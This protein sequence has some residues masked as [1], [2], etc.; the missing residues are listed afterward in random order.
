MK[1]CLGSLKFSLRDEKV[2]KRRPFRQKKLL[3]A[4]L[5]VKLKV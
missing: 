2:L 1:F 5:T 4:A 3:S